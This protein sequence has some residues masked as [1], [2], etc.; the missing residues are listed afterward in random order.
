MN[1]DEYD[2]K[3]G[4]YKTLSKEARKIL[5]G[6]LQFRILYFF[7]HEKWKAVKLAGMI[8]TI[9]FMLQVFVLNRFETQIIKL[10]GSTRIVYIEDSTKNFNAF[11]KDIAELESGGR[12]D[13]ISSLGYMGKYQV[14]RQALTDIGMGGVPVTDFI[15]TPELQEI[16]MRMLLK[17]NKRYLQSYIGK[18][19]SKKVGNIRI[20]ESS[21]LAAAH[22]TG[23]GAVMQFLDSNG[24]VDPVDGNGIKTSS[25][26]KSFRGY[27]LE[28]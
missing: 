7:K 27:K 3:V 12:Y 6:L 4:L 26:L 8:V 17:K 21:L 14:G 15:N 20:D 22:L 9:L 5:W 18:Y 11:L 1:K 10:P 24:I 23:A 28:L 13:I 19:N 2:N 25:R 16:A